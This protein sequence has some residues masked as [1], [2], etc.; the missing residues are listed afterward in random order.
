MVEL[1]SACLIAGQLAEHVEFFSFGGND[2][3]QTALGVSREDASRFLPAYRNQ[4][5][6]LADDPFAHLDPQVAE[7]IRIALDRGKAARPELRAG[8]CGDQGGSPAS[9]ETCEKLGLDFVSAPLAQ[10]PGARLAA[11]QARLR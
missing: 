2:L 3:T 7:L 10:L 6:L 8:L 11:A 4:L 1:P 9:V 5:R